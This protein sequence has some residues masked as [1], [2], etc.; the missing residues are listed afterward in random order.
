MTRRRDLVLSEADS[1]RLADDRAI[2]GSGARSVRRGLAAALIALALF[3]TAVIA[4]SPGLWRDVLDWAQ[5]ALMAAVFSL[6]SMLD[7]YQ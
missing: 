6:D 3:A 1:A 2:V 4:L 7:I 5:H